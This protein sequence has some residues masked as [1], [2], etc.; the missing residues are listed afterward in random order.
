MRW[1]TGSTSRSRREPWLT[2]R[3]RD[4]NGALGHAV[5][6]LLT[7]RER[8]AMRRQLL[9]LDD[10]LLRD[11]GITRLDAQNEADKPFWRV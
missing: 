3:I 6:A 10:R 1:R 7:W 2:R 11:I 9:M 8:A 4:I 5:D